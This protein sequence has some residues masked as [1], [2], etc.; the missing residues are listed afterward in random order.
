MYSEGGSQLGKRGACWWFGGHLAFFY[1]RAGMM[2]RVGGQGGGAG[3]GSAKRE[4]IGSTRILM[5]T[6]AFRGLHLA[7]IWYWSESTQPHFHP[8]EKITWRQ[9]FDTKMFF[10]NQNL[11][12]LP[13]VVVFFSKILERLVCPARRANLNLHRTSVL[14]IKQRKCC[15]LLFTSNDHQVTYKRA[16]SI[17]QGENTDTLTFL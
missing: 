12:I 7:R 1:R 6:A 3:G 9:D 17:D 4:L 13:A 8:P 10:F 16:I 15:Q 5:F 11:T 2:V 14:K